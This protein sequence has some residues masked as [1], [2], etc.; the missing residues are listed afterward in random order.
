MKPEGNRPLLKPEHRSQPFIK[1]TGCEGVSES[2][3]LMTGS[4]FGLYSKH[5]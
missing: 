4:S 3:W 1:L 5:K 2:N